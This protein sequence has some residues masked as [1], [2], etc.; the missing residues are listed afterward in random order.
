[1]VQQARK[2]TKNFHKEIVKMIR[3]Y[4]INLPVDVFN[5]NTLTLLKPYFDLDLLTATNNQQNQWFYN[6]L[7][8]AQQSLSIAHCVQHNQI[9]RLIMQSCFGLDSWPND[10]PTSFDSTI[11]C[12]SGSKAA[13]DLMLTNNVLNGTKHWISLLEQADYGIFRVAVD[14]TDAFVFLDFKSM[15][16]K[17]DMSWM[18]PIGMELAKPG[19]FTVQDLELPTECVLGYKKFYENHPLWSPV[20]NIIDYAFITNYLGLIVSLHH[21]FGEYLDGMG[22]SKDFEFE[23]LGASIA[24]LKMMWKDN[25]FSVGCTKFSDTFWHRRNTQ[26]TMSKDITCQLITLILQQGDSRWLDARSQRSQRMRDAL[27]FCSHMK[28]LSVNLKEKHFFNI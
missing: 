24:G 16:H 25:L 8:L 1:M 26:Y 14:D 4:T 20:L 7:T 6:L 21:E 13:D 10:L 5:K 9:P 11:G 22:R 15:P 3:E 12:Y 18:T 27:T 23:R 17:Q 19:S 28:P 2:Y